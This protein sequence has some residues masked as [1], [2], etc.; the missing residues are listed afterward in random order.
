[1]K[2]GNVCKLGAVS[3]IILAGA[4]LPAMGASV[5]VYQG[6]DAPLSPGLPHPNS[7][8]AAA[9]FSAAAVLV[10]T[11]NFEG[12]APT[13]S[14]SSFPVAPGVTMTTSGLS[15]TLSGLSTDNSN[16]SLG[17]N[18]TAA[19]SEFFRFSN[20]FVNGTGTL[21][22]VDFN[23]IT[24]INAWGAYFTGL[25][26]AAGANVQVQ[27]SDG[28]SQVLSVTRNSSAGVSFFGFTDSGA[29]I[30]K[31]TISEDDTG[32]TTRDIFG[33]D[34]VVYAQNLIPTGPTQGPVAAPVPE[35]VWGGA[36]LLG[37]FG[38]NGARRR[39]AIRKA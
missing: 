15:S 21:G 10:Q 32:Q 2:L 30:S 9:S 12:L 1:M 19:G 16:S 31:V 28:T 3:A 26:S 39:R 23:F 27:F 8:A 6:T 25:E 13:G 35:A 4:S 5:T 29:S 14:F 24:P 37:V 17:F 18:T 20:D 34:D 38:L 36:A 11:I 33:I 22:S 7:S